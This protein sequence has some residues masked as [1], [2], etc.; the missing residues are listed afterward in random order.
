MIDCKD[1]QQVSMIKD[2][3]RNVLTYTKNVIKGREEY[4][5]E[6]MNEEI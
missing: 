6:Q 5:E 1:M 2:R 4:V 3:E